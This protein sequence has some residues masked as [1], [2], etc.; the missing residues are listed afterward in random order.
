MRV[1][2]GMADMPSNRYFSH[3]DLMLF[4]AAVGYDGLSHMDFLKGYR[5]ADPY[6]LSHRFPLLIFVYSL[7]IK[8]KVTL[9]CGRLISRSHMTIETKGTPFKTRLK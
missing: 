2:D 9:C 3:I 4:N 5:A 1:Y 8:N 6:P 7:C